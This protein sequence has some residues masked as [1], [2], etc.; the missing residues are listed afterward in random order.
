M[1]AH[2]PVPLSTAPGQ[3]VDLVNQHNSIPRSSRPSRC[4]TCKERCLIGHWLSERLGQPFIIENRA[5]AGSNLGTEAVMRAPPDG[6]TLLQVTAA[7]AW[8]ATLY[9]NF[10]F[11]FNSNFNS[12]SNF[13]FKRFT[14]YKF[15]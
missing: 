1:M 6:Y 5:G 10:N 4:R 9:D 13:N 15:L 12:N 7:N 2:S 8:N 3:P 14:R 11:N